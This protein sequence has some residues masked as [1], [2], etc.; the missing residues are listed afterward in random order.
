[1]LDYSS[2]RDTPVCPKL[3]M[4][5]PRNQEGILKRLIIRK[6]VLGSSPGEDGLHTSETKYDSAKT[7][8]VC[9]GEDITGTKATAP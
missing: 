4:L 5:M 6:S 3:G 1:M 9:F 2:R 7:K 8:I